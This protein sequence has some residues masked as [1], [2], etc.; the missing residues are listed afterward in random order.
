[1]TKKSNRPENSN[2]SVGIPIPDEKQQKE[3]EKKS[4]S[5]VSDAVEKIGKALLKSNPGMSV[6]YMTSDGNGFYEKND[7][8]NHARILKDKTVVSV[9]Q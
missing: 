1:M 9:K 7:A 8:N 2:D 5:K 3:A 6:V 4:E